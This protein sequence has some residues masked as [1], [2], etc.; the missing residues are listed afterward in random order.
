MTVE[1]SFTEG[2]AILAIWM[3]V[4][5]ASHTKRLIILY[6][7]NEVHLSPQELVSEGLDNKVIE[8]V[9]TWVEKMA[10]KHNLPL[11]AP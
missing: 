2:Q 3:K 11:I 1:L 10:F 5:L 8:A 4:S 9:K 7:L 6:G